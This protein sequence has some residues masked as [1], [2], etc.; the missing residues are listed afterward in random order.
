MA[1]ACVRHRRT[2]WREALGERRGGGE[3]EKGMA[4]NKEN[5]EKYK[6]KVKGEK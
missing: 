5:E 6:S 4:G 3:E 2:W 1:L